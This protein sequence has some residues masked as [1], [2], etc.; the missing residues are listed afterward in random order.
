MKCAI[1]NEAIDARSDKEAA[2]IAGFCRRCSTQKQGGM[3]SARGGKIE[4][5]RPPKHG[6]PTLDVVRC[7]P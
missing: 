3:Y 2:R 1:C 6:H 7:Y 4:V 5:N